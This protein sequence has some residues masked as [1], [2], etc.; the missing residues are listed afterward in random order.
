MNMTGGVRMLC[1]RARSVRAFAALCLML[2]ALI[3]VPTG[4]AAGSWAGS[5][6]EPDY[7]KIDNWVK[8]EMGQ[9][10]IP[11]LSLAIVKGQDIV[12]T[13]AFGNADDS[14]RA[15]TTQTPFVLSSISKTF[16]ALAIRQLV[17]AGKVDTQ[18]PVEM[19]LPW[20][21]P[22]DEGTTDEITIQT[23]LD[24]RSGY[25]TLQGDEPYLRDPQ[26]TL[27]DLVRKASTITP[28]NPTGTYQYSNLNYLILGMVVQQV[29]GQPYDK[30]VRQN[31]FAPLEMHNSY[32]D[33]STAERNGLATGHRLIFGFPAAYKVVSAPAMHAAGYQ[34]SSAEDMGNYLIAYLNGGR[35]KNTSVLVPAGEPAPTAEGGLHD[36]YWNPLPGTTDTGN[37]S[38]QSGGSVNYNSDLLIAPALHMGV[39]VLTNSRT[40]MLAPGVSADLIALTV[41]KMMLGTEPPAPSDQG[42]HLGWVFIDSVLLL[43]AAFAVLQVMRLPHWGTSLR[44]PRTRPILGIWLP[45]AVDFALA[46]VLLAGLPV[47]IRTPWDL[48][49]IALPDVAYTLCAVGIVLAVVGLIKTGFAIWGRQRLPGTVGRPVHA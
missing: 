43:L 38:G 21:T 4:A 47:F 25:S 49:F 37:W 23:L 7:A 8:A 13:A 1:N 29:S 33:D 16:T 45:I 3:V 10:P 32:N 42:F 39:I 2:A 48:A 28:E 24:H 31:I 30:Y 15:V 22:V 26:Y 5:R 18:A 40:N 17:N 41:M 20:F 27:E 11:G 14:G 34:I 9:A 35:Y 12:H 36:I 19:Y 6:G 46:A 44:E